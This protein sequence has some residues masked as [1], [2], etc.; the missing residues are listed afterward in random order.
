MGDKSWQSKFKASLAC[1]LGSKSARTSL[2]NPVFKKKK[3]RRKR[4]LLSESYVDHPKSTAR[5]VKLREKLPDSNN[6]A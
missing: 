3:W 2:S 6:M 4:H 5:K 1:V